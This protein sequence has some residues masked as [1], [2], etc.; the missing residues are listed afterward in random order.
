MRRNFAGAALRLIL[1]AGV[2][3]AATGPEFEAA[4]VKPN[5]SGERRQSQRTAGRTFRATN[6]LA[7][8]LLR[9]AYGL[10]FEDYRLLGAPDWLSVERF[11]VVATLPEQAPL[12][13]GTSHAAGHAG[14]S[15]QAGHPHRDARSAR[16]RRSYWRAKMDGSVRSSVMP[17]KTAERPAQPRRVR[18]MSIPANSRSAARSADAASLWISLP[19]HC[20]SLLDARLW[21][22]PA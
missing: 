9:Q 6:V 15:L 19:K 20:C 5:V 22:E 13:P 17:Q 7:R 2:V 10:M 16:P 1:A 12:Q 21:I 14:G 4:S 3:W 8:N 18:M 11:D